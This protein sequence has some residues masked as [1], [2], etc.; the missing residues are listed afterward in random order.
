MKVLVKNKSVLEGL[1]E[2]LLSKINEEFRIFSEDV[3]IDAT[4]IEA[5]TK[6][7]KSENLQVAS[8]SKQLEMTVEDIINELPI[9][10][11]WGVKSNSE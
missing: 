7:Q 10:P 2:V 9:Y 6:S 11:S 3:A 4:A 5:H 8:T 1:N